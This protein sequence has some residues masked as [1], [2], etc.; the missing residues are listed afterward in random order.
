MKKTVLFFVLA[1]S[2]LLM[3]ACRGEYSVIEESADEPHS[4]DWN[5]IVQKLADQCKAKIKEDWESMAGLYSYSEDSFEY[6]D[7]KRKMLEEFRT[8]STLD[9]SYDVHKMEF[10]GARTKA[11]VHASLDR[12]D[13]SRKT[14]ESK[15]YTVEFPP[16]DDPDALKLEKIG[17]VWLFCP[18]ENCEG[19]PTDLYSCSD[20]SLVDIPE[21]CPTFVDIVPTNMTFAECFKQHQDFEEIFPNTIGPYFLNK[22]SIK[23]VEDEELIIKTEENELDKFLIVKSFKADYQHKED[24]KQIFSLLF[25]KVQEPADFEQM[26]TAIME[27]IE[28]NKIMNNGTSETSTVRG[29]KMTSLDFKRDSIKF[30]DRFKMIT[31]LR[32]IGIPEKNTMLR[33]NFNGWVLEENIPKIIATYGNLVCR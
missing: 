29:S 16:E 9:C 22:D 27:E 7:F 26:N 2:L 23:I 25:R 24:N 20:G 11:R 6:K 18:T 14:F 8:V 32:Y 5:S 13:T 1:V 21:Q 3:T 33:F 31:N 28:E 17:G 19:S 30:E 15:I 4:E 12:K 10:N